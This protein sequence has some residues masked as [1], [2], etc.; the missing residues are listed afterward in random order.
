[1]DFN[2]IFIYKIL[3]IS[4]V[5]IAALSIIFGTAGLISPRIISQLF[6]RKIVVS[7]RNILL[8]ATSLFSFSFATGG[9]CALLY[10]SP[11]EFFLCKFLGFFT[12]CLMPLSL[13]LGVISLFSPHFLS[14]LLR[15]TTVSNRL[16]IFFGTLL[17]FSLFGILTLVF[18]FLDKSIQ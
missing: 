13:A 8:T 4:F 14:W 15:K 6:R 10:R 5:S 7:R 18:V 3:G 1:M 16:T 9:T 12:L 17:L 11:N 2:Q